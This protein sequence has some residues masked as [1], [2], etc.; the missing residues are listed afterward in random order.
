MASIL[1]SHEFN[2]S[3]ISYSEPKKNSMNG[4][5]ILINY[6][7]SGRNGPVVIQTP[8]LRVPFGFDRQEPEGGG[9]VRFSVNV[10]VNNDGNIGKFYEVV[11][12]LEAHVKKTAVEKS[13]TWFGKKKSQEV[14]EDDLFKS[15]IKYPKQKD[16][17]D[18]TVRIK[19]PYNDKG[20]QF[21]LEDENKIPISLS[22]DE[23][24]DFSA[25]SPGCEITAII[26]C[27]GV[28]FI[29]KSSF[30][31]GFKLLKARVYSNNRLKNLT[32]IDDEEEDASY[33]DY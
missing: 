9:A 10:S 28:Y 12:K 26:Q 19:L 6:N 3:N 20:P 32:I 7:Q 13:E 27:T 11:Q 14:I 18:P 15:V 8:R 2:E 1:L 29:G 22:V 25:L 24:F 17:Y 16:K 33:E 31:I 5:N 23:E 21:S 4:Q 30:G